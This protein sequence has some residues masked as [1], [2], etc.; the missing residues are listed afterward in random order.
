MPETLINTSF[1]KIIKNY[2]TP[3]GKNYP[4]FAVKHRETL[5]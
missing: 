1:L 3:K 5:S 2:Q 4:V